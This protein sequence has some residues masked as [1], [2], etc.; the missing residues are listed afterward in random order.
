MLFF[1]PIDYSYR[2]IDAFHTFLFEILLSTLYFCN[3]MRKAS[4]TLVLITM[5]GS[6]CEKGQSGQQP[7]TILPV[8][9]G[10]IEENGYPMVMLSSNQAHFAGTL[11]PGN[12]SGWIHGALVSVSNGPQ[13]QQLREYELTGAD[14]QP[15]WVYTVD[16][17]R[18]SDAFRGETGK[19]YTLTIESEGK[20]LTAI[21]TIPAHSLRL[22]SAWSASG[23]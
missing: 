7:D 11:P 14:G 2:R 18:L 19:S 4:F 17:A 10:I 13:S 16:T 3:L 1:I 23:T 5:I 20:R 6:A 12:T 22:D 8:V 9:E 21:T 15:F